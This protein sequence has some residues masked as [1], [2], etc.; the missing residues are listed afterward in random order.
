[1]VPMKLLLK[2]KSNFL[3]DKPVKKGR[4]IHHPRL[5][6]APGHLL[7]PMIITNQGPQQFGSFG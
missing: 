5:Y 4:F 2:I 7:F 3:A 1:M 6:A